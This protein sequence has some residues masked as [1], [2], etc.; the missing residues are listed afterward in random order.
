[1]PIKTLSTNQYRRLSSKANPRIE[2]LQRIKESQRR[3]PDPNIRVRRGTNGDTIMNESAGNAPIRPIISAPNS[4]RSS[5]KDT[6]GIERLRDKP[7]AVTAA[8]MMMIDLVGL[9]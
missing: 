5:D 9:I 8:I 4:R 1:M 7:I 2:A 3:A 6:S